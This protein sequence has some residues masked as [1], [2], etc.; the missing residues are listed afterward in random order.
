MYD[1]FHIIY[2]IIFEER[3]GSIFACS[4]FFIFY[5]NFLQKIYDFLYTY[6]IKLKKQEIYTII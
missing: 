4:F 3:T 5:F 6:Q 1:I 2:G